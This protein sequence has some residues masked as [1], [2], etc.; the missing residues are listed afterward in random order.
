M[1][2]EPVLSAGGVIVP[3]PGYVKALRDLAHELGMLRIMD[4]SQTGLAK[5]GRMWGHQ[6]EAVVPDIMTV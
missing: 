2:L 6:H 5:T 1:I 4:E 3:P